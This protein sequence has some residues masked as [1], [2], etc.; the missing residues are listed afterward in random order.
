MATLCFCPPLNS[1]GFLYNK[2]SIPSSFDIFI[3]LIF[4]SFFDILFKDKAISILEYTSI[5]LIKLYSWNIN[6]IFSPRYISNFLGLY[7]LIEEAL[8]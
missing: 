1:N 7:S 3:I 8:N 2:S 5:V 4:L 6:P